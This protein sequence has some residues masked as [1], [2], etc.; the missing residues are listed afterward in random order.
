[1]IAQPRGSSGDP[2]A[3]AVE[4][5]EIGCVVLLQRGAIGPLHLRELARIVVDVARDPVGT[6]ASLRP[7]RARIGRERGLRDYRT[8]IIRA[9]GL[10][11]ELSMVFPELDDHNSLMLLS[12]LDQILG[13]RL[14]GWIAKDF[15]D[16]ITRV[17]PLVQLPGFRIGLRQHVNE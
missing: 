12:P 17:A 13:E 2:R 16:P 4:A 9:N 14:V 7:E 11:G 3:L 10:L 5:V 1:M 6:L 8:L 15:A